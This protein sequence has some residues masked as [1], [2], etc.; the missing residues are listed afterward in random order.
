MF[1][2]MQRK[3]ID[4]KHIISM[5]F[6]KNYKISKW[7]KKKDLAYCFFHVPKYCLQDNID[8]KETFIFK[9][10]QLESLI[11]SQVRVLLNVS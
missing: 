11:I 1:Q 5:N 9:G 10:Q 2:I 8:Q 6:L 4:S 7:F 3:M